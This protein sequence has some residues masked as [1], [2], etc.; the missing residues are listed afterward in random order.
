MKPSKDAQ[1]FLEALMFAYTE[2]E[3]G[4]NP[5]DNFTV[6]DFSPEFVAGLESFIEGFRA[7]LDER[8]IEIPDSPRS[9]GGN[10]YF[11]LSGHGCGFQDEDETKELQTALVEYSGDNYRFE[12]ID[13]MPDEGGRLDLAFK[14]EYRKEYRAKLFAL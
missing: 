5:V 2:D 14:P 11:S 12:E 8:Q 4:K 13:L 1:D 10:V 6:W 7:Y 9:F 3:Q